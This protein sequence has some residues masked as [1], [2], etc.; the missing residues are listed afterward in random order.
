M[1]RVPS[2]MLTAAMLGATMNHLAVEGPPCPKESATARPLPRT[3]RH[4]APS[5]AVREVD[6]VFIDRER[7]D[8]AVSAL[9][10]GGVRYTDMTAVLERH[11]D[12]GRRIAV[13]DLPPGDF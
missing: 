9:A 5:K 12:G 3:R 1:M 13:T 10:D 4:P 2:A 6:G 11:L 7:L 8:H